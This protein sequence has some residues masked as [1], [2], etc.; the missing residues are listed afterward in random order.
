MR[1]II[2]QCFMAIICLTMQAQNKD[3][4]IVLAKNSGVWVS[5]PETI[6]DKKSKKKIVTW[7]DTEKNDWYEQNIILDNI[8]TV[9]DID[10]LFPEIAHTPKD[11]PYISMPWRLTE[12]NDETILHCYLQMPADIVNKFW[13]TD[14]EGA[15]LDKET[16]ITYRARRT[17]P[18]CYRQL[19]GIKAK[20][21]SILDFKIIFPKLPETT[22]DIAI[23]GVPNWFLRG[24][25]V[26]LNRFPSK[27]QVYGTISYYDTIPK[28][29]KP[30]LVIPAKDYDKDNFRTWAEYKDA[31]LIK[32]VKENTMGMW[33][34]PEAT[35]LAI[36][37]ELN[38]VR[39]FF[40]RGNSV[41]L[42]DQLGHQYKCKEVMDYPKG[43]LFW[44]QGY[45]GDYF[46][47][48]LVFE[49][50]P[51]TLETITYIEPEDEPF[52]VRNAN[53]DGMVLPNLSIKELRANQKLF[54]YHPRIIVK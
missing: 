49:P 38:W 32:P 6:I 53:W 15:I 29:H 7:F 16:G 3:D 4:V 9:K 35:Y 52:H 44:V 39:E 46:A 42:M 47:I 23:Y 27:W 5:R 26:T 31:H 18:N 33:I 50:I 17:E 21:G 20:E 14:E 8:P 43:T 28:F 36:S 19:F 30:Q 48:V 12:E 37:T 51:L 11:M 45:S 40:G 10:V 25:D 34:T 13:L 22:R 41:M 2:T 1:R 54:D 24:M